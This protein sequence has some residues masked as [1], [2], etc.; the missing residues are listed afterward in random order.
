MFENVVV[1]IG[2][3]EG[4]RD[5][6]ALAQQLLTG[7]ADLTL[8]H[9]Y[10]GDPYVYR[11]VSA[12]FEE[13]ERR[14]DIERL[15]HARDEARVRASV[16][17]RR[18]SSV[19]HG[20]HELCKDI[21]ADLLVVGASRRRGL[22][23]LLRGDDA[24]SALNDAPCAV[25]IA[26]AGYGRDPVRIRKIGT[27]YDGSPESKHALQVARDLAAA[28]GGKISALDAVYLPTS[29]LY[30][31]I[32][33]DEVEELLEAARDDLAALGGLEPHAAYGNPVERLTLYSASVDLL[34]IG[35]H[36]D[37][38]SPTLLHTSTA[39]ELARTT[40]CPLL[41]LMRGAS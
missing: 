41:A 19:G 10:A 1:G 17:W 27:A 3:S 38:P 28:R 22:P 35:S 12:E 4:G 16:R 11:G 18:A 14:Q 13:S 34:V 7:D 6:I 31:T 15:S 23:K 33:D 39:R 29:A 36:H 9:V 2:D 21:G 5:A 32:P 40:Y 8:A 26:P 30:M 25:A 20:L 37:G 24:R